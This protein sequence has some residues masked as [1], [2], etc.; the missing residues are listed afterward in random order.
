VEQVRHEAHVLGTGQQTVHRREL[1]GHPDH[2]TDGGRFGVE[3]EPENAHVA[4]VGR[5]EGRQDLHSGCLAGAVRPEKTE[6]RTGRDVEVDVVE[7]DE[8][9][10]GLAE[11]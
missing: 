11:S 1:A 6:H 2:R 5:D 10:V 8:V 4:A 9:A 7:D 3:L